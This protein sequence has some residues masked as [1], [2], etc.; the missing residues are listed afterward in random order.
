MLF[1]PDYE[2]G[3][4]DAW[5]AKPQTR[6]LADR[7]RRAFPADELDYKRIPGGL[8]VQDRDWDIE[9]RETMTVVAGSRHRGAVGQPAL[10]VARVQ[11]RLRRTRS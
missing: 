6:I 3:A 11:A 8:L 5:S 1:A 2:D 7:E 9:T 4:L 10:R